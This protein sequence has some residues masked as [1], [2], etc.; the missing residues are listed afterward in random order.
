MSREKT[1]DTNWVKRPS[2][3]LANDPKE[4]LAQPGK[5][6]RLHPRLPL[7]VRA[8]IQIGGAQQVGYLTNLSQGGAFLATQEPPAI[9]TPVHLHIFLPWKLGDFEA[10]AKTVWSSGDGNET[11]PPGVGLR[12]TELDAHAETRLRAYVETFL[13]LVAQ[14]EE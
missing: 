13:R 7:V 5:E 3:T 10:E 9:G 12:F 1:S 4:K 11:Y 8:E 14:I 6:N 2:I